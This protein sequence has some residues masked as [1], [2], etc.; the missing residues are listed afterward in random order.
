[1]T[2][3]GSGEEAGTWERRIVLKGREAYDAGSFVVAILS[4]GVFDEVQSFVCV[5]LEVSIKFLLVKYLEQPHPCEPRSESSL[6]TLIA[7]HS[8]PSRT[9][10]SIASSVLSALAL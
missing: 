3:V 1:M 8:T 9:P 7:N 4:A 6:R 10:L 2:G 5:G